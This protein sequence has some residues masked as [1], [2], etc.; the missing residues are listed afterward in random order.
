MVIDDVLE[1]KYVSL[2]CVN[3]NDAAFTGKLRADDNLCA[4]IHKVDTTLEGQ[5]RW[6]RYQRSLVDDLYFIIQK[7]EKP[8]GT[9]ALY[10][11]TDNTAEIGRWV[12]YGNSFENL[13]AVIL[14]HDYAFNK[15]N[16]KQVYTC[17]NI[18]NEKVKSFWKRFGSDELYEEMQS[19]F[20]ASKN[21][22]F[23]ETYKCIIRP[24][25]GKL[26]KY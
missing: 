7:D 15:L 22:I 14:L 8:I 12:S 26:L 24:R 20:M 18:F 9:I 21:I 6:I 16:L 17:T 13:E 23:S 10:N 1:G 11:I 2:R 25:M 3:E 5:L 19:D 4:L